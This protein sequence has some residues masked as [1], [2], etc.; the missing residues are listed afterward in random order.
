MSSDGCPCFLGSRVIG[1]TEGR[2]SL[3]CSVIFNS[4]VNSSA[5]SVCKC[6]GGLDDFFF[7]CILWLNED[8]VLDVLILTV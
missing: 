4:Y 3:D 6:N 5:Q 2:F 1:G 8:F 7:F